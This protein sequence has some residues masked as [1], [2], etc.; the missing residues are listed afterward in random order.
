MSEEMKNESV[1]DKKIS[2][3]SMLKWTG[4]LA[5]AV[6]VGAGAE[7]GATELLK[8]ATPTQVQVPEEKVLRSTLQGRIRRQRLVTIRK[9]SAAE[10]I[11]DETGH[12]RE[13]GDTEA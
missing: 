9:T 11:L 3:R 12:R 10:T 4:A 5:A 2:R 13:R 7:Y 6:A 1:T 8:P